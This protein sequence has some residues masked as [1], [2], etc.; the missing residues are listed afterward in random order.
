MNAKQEKPA[1]RAALLGLLLLAGTTAATGAGAQ[2]P[3]GE[4][5]VRRGAMSLTAGLTT[6]L[7]VGVWR[8]ASDRT[9]LGV[10]ASVATQRQ[11]AGESFV[12]TR[13]TF[14]IGPRLRHYGSTT[15][16]LLP[17]LQGGLSGELTR[18]S[19]RY[20][21]TSEQVNRNLQRS[22][23]ADFGAGLEWFPVSRI[24]VGGQAGLRASRALFRQENEQRTVG[25]THDSVYDSTSW[26]VGTFTSGIE[27][28][29]FF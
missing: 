16:A 25:G 12:S 9:G 29:L 10:A 11:E 19:T 20:Q 8:M 15:G 6:G 7:Q 21:G 23:V 27:A 3:G 17:Y 26:R 14:G 22:L 28:R 4:N 1:P 13:Q 2:E 24:S 18:S 5:S